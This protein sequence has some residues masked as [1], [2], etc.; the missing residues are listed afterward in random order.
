VNKITSA[1][2]CSSYSPSQLALSLREA[3]KLSGSL[4]DVKGKTVLLKPNILSA[5]APEKAVTTHPEFVKQCVLLFLELGAKEVL[6][7]DS[8]GYHSSEAGGKKSGIT[9]AVTNAGGK[10]VD[11]SDSITVKNPEGKLVKS[12]NLASVIKKADV[13]VSLPKMKTHKLLYYTGAMKNIFGLVP[14]LQ[15]ASFHLRFSDRNLFA[16]MIVDLNLAVKNVYSIMDGITA[17]EG[18]GPGSGNPRHAGVILASSNPLAL[19]IAAS[20]I[21]GYN[22]LDLPV[23]ADALERKYW[24]GSAYDFEVR[25]ENIGSLVI[26]DFDRIKIL[27]DVSMFRDKMPRFFFNLLKQATIPRPVFDHGKCIECGYCVRICP[28]GALT[29][30]TGPDSRIHIDYKKC[31]NCYCC[32]EICPA[33]AI[34]TK[35]L[36]FPGK[37]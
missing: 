8:P 5:S 10:W 13:I 17:M 21:M 16:R 36:L 26:K 9:E 23:I 32:H 30:P 6:A 4:P 19:D 33:K 20:S 1:V 15:K 25:G 37:G 3:V 7:G 27:K 34:S 29:L 28:A 35:K 22:P 18:E 11:F 2:R 31:I 24:L 14:G 12:F